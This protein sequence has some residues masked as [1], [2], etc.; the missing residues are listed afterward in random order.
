MTGKVQSIQQGTKE[1]RP[2]LPANWGSISA[3][4]RTEAIISR[5]DLPQF[6][7][8]LPADK[9][10]L[11]I[12]DL[13][14]DSSIELFSYVNKEQWRGLVD[15][16]CW[17]N[18]ST[19]PPKFSAWFQAA[20][21]AGNTV[22]K[23]LLMAVDEEYFVTLL[24][25]IGTVEEKDLDKDF[26]PDSL[27]IIP[28]PD[29]EFFLLIPRNHELIP[30]VVQTLKIIFG[31]SILKG[32]RLLRSCRTELSTQLTE[33][34]FQFRAAR[35][36]DL[37]FLSF[38]AAVEI[39]EPIALNSLRER[40]GQDLAQEDRTRYRPLHQSIPGLMLYGS[41]QALFLHKVLAAIPASPQKEAMEE[42]F[43]YLI[44]RH[45]IAAKVEMSDTTGIQ[46][47][48]LQTYGMVNLGL[49][50][51]VGADVEA[52]VNALNSLWLTELYRAGYT[53]LLTVQQASRKLLGKTAEFGLF[54]HPLDSL[55]H[56][57]SGLI[58][59]AVQGFT[60]EGEAVL[61]PIAT[62][63]ELRNVSASVHYAES[64][65]TVFSERLGIQVR[66]LKDDPLPGVPE[67]QRQG[68]TYRTLLLTGLANQII[69][70]GFSMEVLNEDH[71]ER[72]ANII[73]SGIGEARKIRP[74]VREQLLEALDSSLQEDPA[75]QK[76]MHLF[77]GQ[78]L[79][80][81][82]ESLKALPPG[83]AIDTRFLGPL[84]LTEEK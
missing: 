82:E 12:N 30:F 53:R 48:A 83:E 16:S 50:T 46:V 10:Y 40:L 28:S 73:L 58:P 20:I 34:A 18:D 9:L 21:L 23:D 24:M 2:S 26:V 61:R 6:V 33:T 76:A 77:L 57:V 32:R 45:C 44:N 63:S 75:V 15:I 36:E 3:T 47:G 37:G 49:E 1:T 41:Q 79:D 66:S 67:K 68:L 39:L 14:V 80:Q 4:E 54:N 29:G 8:S 64:I 27:E 71:I 62:L 42:Y 51:L 22:A 11:L 59:S 5:P 55:L 43:T 74:E 78:S 65:A 70:R 60:E 25:S 38:D 52:G 19:S 13:G 72:M 17:E 69:G 7:D 81:L 35:L 84:F 56:H 31:E